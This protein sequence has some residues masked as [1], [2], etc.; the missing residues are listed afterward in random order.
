MSEHPEFV[1]TDEIEEFVRAHIRADIAW[2]HR[3]KRMFQTDHREFAMGVRWGICELLRQLGQGEW[4]DQ[5]YREEFEDF[6]RRQRAKF[7]HRQG[8]GTRVMMPGSRKL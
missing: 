5:I 2:A 7:F 3:P 1:I 4:A 6:Q 8:R